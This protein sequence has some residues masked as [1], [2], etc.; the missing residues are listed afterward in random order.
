MDVLLNQIASQGVLGTLLA[1]SILANIWLVRQLLAEKD[2]RILGAERTRD[3]LIA[4][5][6]FIKDSL[7]LIQQK[8]QISKERI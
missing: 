5:I 8:V 1:L 4:P 7:E 3:E 2:R 6:G